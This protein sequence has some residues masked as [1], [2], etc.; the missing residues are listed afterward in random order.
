M[1]PN[2]GPI[3]INEPEAGDEWVYPLGLANNTVVYH[4][5]DPIKADRWISYVSIGSDSSTVYTY[6]L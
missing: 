2:D 6:E 1:Q 5:L 3:T 4:S